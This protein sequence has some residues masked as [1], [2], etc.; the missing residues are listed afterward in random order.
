MPG[1]VGESELGELSEDLENMDP[2]ASK[3]VGTR[4]SELSAR[5][6]PAAQV[7]AAKRLRDFL[8]ESLTRAER[9]LTWELEQEFGETAGSLRRAHNPRT[10]FH[11]L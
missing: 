3:C 5:D 10:Q 11:R 7:L 6:A 8:E 1:L 9:R 2:K 4:C